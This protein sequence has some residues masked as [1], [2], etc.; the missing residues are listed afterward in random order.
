MSSFDGGMFAVFDHA[1]AIC[2]AKLVRFGLLAAF[3]RMRNS[4]C[5]LT[6]PAEVG[7]CVA[8]NVVQVGHMFLNGGS[9]EPSRAIYFFPGFKWSGMSGSSPTAFSW[10]CRSSVI[11]LRRLISC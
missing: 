9:T 7:L 8:L 2:F 3:F 11:F 6:L 5:C 4:P 1:L 10:P